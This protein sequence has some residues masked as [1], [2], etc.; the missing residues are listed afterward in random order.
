[1]KLL[2]RCIWFLTSA[3]SCREA[4]SR[5]SSPSYPNKTQP[6]SRLS[7]YLRSR[8]QTPSLECSRSSSVWPIC[9]R[10]PFLISLELVPGSQGLRLRQ[11]NKGS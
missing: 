1:M 10:H 2:R 8:S 11:Q 3:T 5:P 7:P 6:S 9:C 4:F